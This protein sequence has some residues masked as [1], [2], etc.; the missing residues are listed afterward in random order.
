MTVLIDVSDPCQSVP[1]VVLEGWK[2]KGALID[3]QECPSLLGDS[4]SAGFFS[5]S[6][7]LVKSGMKIKD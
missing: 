3:G 2:K 4:S 5:S 6:D 1:S 7:A